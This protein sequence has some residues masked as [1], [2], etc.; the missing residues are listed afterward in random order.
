MVI[1][2]IM[3]KLICY[4]IISRQRWDPLRFLYFLILVHLLN[5][6]SVYLDIQ[7]MKNFLIS[8]KKI[9]FWWWKR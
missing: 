9:V 8:L 6:I 3:R 5:I 7:G 2:M 1:D 4:I